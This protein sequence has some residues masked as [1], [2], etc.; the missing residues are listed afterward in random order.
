MF[1]ITEQ[2]KEKCKKIKYYFIVKK[3]NEKASDLE[4][5]K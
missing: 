2:K 4:I 3:I 5:D 1:T